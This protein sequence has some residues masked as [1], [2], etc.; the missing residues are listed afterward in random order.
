MD[1]IGQICNPIRVK[2]CV[3]PN[4]I[5]ITAKKTSVLPTKALN[6]VVWSS[7]REDM[8]VQYISYRQDNDSEDCS[9]SAAAILVVYK[10]ASM[11]FLCQLLYQSC[12]VSDEQFWQAY[13]GLGQEEICLTGGGTICHSKWKISSQTHQGCKSIF[14]I[15]CLEW[16][17]SV[18]VVQR[19]HHVWW[20]FQLDFTQFYNRIAFYYTVDL[21]R[22]T[23]I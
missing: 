9:T 19:C 21:W 2:T 11:A 1:E 23:I 16:L 18:M 12:S 4:P 22:K 10:S 20:L 7:F 6:A 5:I 13:Y 8:T 14:I 17:Y 3:I 15:C